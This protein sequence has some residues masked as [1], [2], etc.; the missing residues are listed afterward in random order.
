MKD[1]EIK[2]LYAVTMDWRS[3]RFE[4]RY[5]DEFASA[6]DIGNLIS[7]LQWCLKKSAGATEEKFPQCGSRTAAPR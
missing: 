6:P 4:V 3:N 7:D 5:S 1:G 2:Q